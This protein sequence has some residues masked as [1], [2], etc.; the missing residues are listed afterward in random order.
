MQFCGSFIC[1]GGT[2]RDEEK[3]YLTICE[4]CEKE[5]PDEEYDEDHDD[6]IC[7]DCRRKA[8]PLLP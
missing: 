4:V 3:E 5:R 1:E 8:K 2:C 6:L 7:N